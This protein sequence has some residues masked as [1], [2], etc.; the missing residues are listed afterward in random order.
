MLL[1]QSR[2]GPEVALGHPAVL[3]ASRTRT[4]LLDIEDDVVSAG[5][6]SKGEQFRPVTAPRVGIPS[7]Q[8][9]TVGPVSTGE[10]DGVREAHAVRIGTIGS[11]IE[12]YLT[13]TDG[14]IADQDRRISPNGVGGVIK[15]PPVSQRCC[16]S[17]ARGRANDE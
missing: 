1:V 7:L 4:S 9:D 11:S 14:G 15:G 16:A 8:A 3:N 2:P 10:V 17:K 12:K 5:S 13:T 6:I